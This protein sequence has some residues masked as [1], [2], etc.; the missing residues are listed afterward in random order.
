MSSAPV[1]EKKLDET[2]ETKETK[3]EDKS[4]TGGSVETKLFA[5]LDQNRE[6]DKQLL[7]AHPSQEDAAKAQNQYILNAALQE[8]KVDIP[9]LNE[10]IKQLEKHVVIQR[11]KLVK[12]E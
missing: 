7:S 10:V 12:D 6:P 5:V 8:L 11:T 3:V 9:K 4:K 1:E 2:K